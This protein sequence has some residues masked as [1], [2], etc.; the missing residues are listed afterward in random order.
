MAMHS[1][2]FLFL[3]NWI[4][5]NFASQLVTVRARLQG[6]GPRGPSARPLGRLAA[7]PSS[8][9]LN[10][11]KAQLT[12]RGRISVWIVRQ[13]ITRT[14]DAPPVDHIADMLLSWYWDPSRRYI[15]LAKIHPS[16]L[17]MLAMPMHLGMASQTSPSSPCPKADLVQ[18]TYFEPAPPKQ[19]VYESPVGWQFH[20]PATCFLKA[21]HVDWCYSAAAN[22]SSPVLA[23]C[24]LPK[25]LLISYQRAVLHT[26]SLSHVS[27]D[28]FL[29]FSW[30]STML[31]QPLQFSIVVV[32]H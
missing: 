2:S 10:N 20:L 1:M 26:W 12:M 15:Q 30:L 24:R 3:L 32:Q 8:S 22:C 31:V 7:R 4:S 6:P 11:L 27:S 25:Q 14:F 16:M 28:P 23:K 21:F 29:S 5:P 17:A 9:A 19:V 13:K 18:P